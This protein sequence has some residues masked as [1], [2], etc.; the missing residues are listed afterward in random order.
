MRNVA[1]RRFILICGWWMSSVTHEN[2]S[3]HVWRIF[4]FVLRWN[5][6][7]FWW[8]IGL[9]WWNVGLFRETHERVQFAL[10]VVSHMPISH[11]LH[12][13]MILVILHV[14]EYRPLLI[15]SRAFFARALLK[16][17]CRFLLIWV[18]SFTGLFWNESCCFTGLFYRSLLMW[19][20]SFIH[21]S[22]HSYRSLLVSLVVSHTDVKS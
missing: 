12:V 16:N 19:V 6:G 17:S 20:V 9:F 1:V 13:W 4:P 5:T 2:E 15:Q 10:W 18:V 7:L 14:T 11:S 8:K 3:L 21:E 22:C